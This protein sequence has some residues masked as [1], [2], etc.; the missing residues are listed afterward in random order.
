MTE[1]TEIARDVF[2]L[3]Y[4]VLDVNVT[5]VVGA[6]AALVVD[7]LSTPGQAAELLTAI[8]RITDAPLAVANTHHHFDHCFGNATLHPAAVYAHEETAQLLRNRGKVLPRQVYAH[9]ATRVPE[10]ADVLDVTIRPPDHTVQH[11]ST[12]DIGGRAV[13]LR[14]LGRGHTGGD[15]VVDIPDAGVVVAG[16]LVEEG[17]APQFEDAY[18]LQ[19]P[20]T[21]A[22]LL[23]LDPVT[24]VPGHG[25][26]CDLAF[27]HAQHDELSKLAWLIR[28]GHA[29]NVAPAKVCAAA[30]Y[31][32]RTAQTAV[33]R[34]YAELDGTI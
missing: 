30:P 11:E 14:H 1:F 27:V 34:G 23:E 20:G 29:D 18:P 10:L 15:L 28:D 26:L 33:E 8:R 5:L 7:T 2:V 9:W 19:W 4:P 32:P 13:V 17:G 25:A 6:G 12:V 24:V 22:A 21:L 31:D 16:D 3:R